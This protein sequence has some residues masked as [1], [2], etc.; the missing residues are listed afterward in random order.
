MFQHKHII[1]LKLSL[2]EE[3]QRVQ[4]NSVLLDVTA[5]LEQ[6]YHAAGPTVPT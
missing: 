3:G 6:V 4:M 5:A 1:L 2:G